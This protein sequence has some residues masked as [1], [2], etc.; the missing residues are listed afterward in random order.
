MMSYMLFFIS[1]LVIQVI[2]Q[3]N[4]FESLL[5]FLPH[6]SLI[7]KLKKNVLTEAHKINPAKLH[8]ELGYQASI[9]QF[10]SKIDLSLVKVGKITSASLTKSSAK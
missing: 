7:I 6:N 5:Y 4:E 2:F 8:S 9:G 1:F 3:M 10:K